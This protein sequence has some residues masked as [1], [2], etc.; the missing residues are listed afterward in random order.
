MYKHI[1]VA[2]DGS[3]TSN[4][5]L[6]EAIKL[7]KEQQ[8]QLRIVH[9]AEDIPLNIDTE[10]ALEAYQEAMRKTGEDV[11]SKADAIARES[12]LTPETKL[13]QI[14]TLGHRV[15][16]MVV[17]EAQSWPADLIV[18][19]THGRRGFNHLLM[20][21]VAE[22]IVRISPKPVLLIRGK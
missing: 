11:L 17:E 10:Y 20:G 7:A 21:S 22:G 4:L 9:V 19:G 18:L 8:A 13:I 6:Q 14:E 3:D 12:G 2:V 5:A 16:N 1:L 15:A